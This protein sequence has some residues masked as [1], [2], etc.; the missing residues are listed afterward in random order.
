MKLTK[1]RCALCL[2]VFFLSLGPPDLG[3]QSAGSP[4]RAASA[5]ADVPDI[6]TRIKNSG[7]AVPP[8]ALPAVPGPV[9]SALPPAPDVPVASPA[10]VPPAAIGPEPAPVDASTP[11][12]AA[13]I[14][15]RVDNP[16]SGLVRLGAGSPET[17]FGDLSVRREDGTLPALALDFS[18]ASAD[19]YGYE[20]PG[21][22]YFDRAAQAR[23]GASSG[24]TSGS[25]PN[26]P[27]A[28]AT[29]DGAPGDASAGAR[30]PAWFAD[31]SLFDGSDG[32]QGKNP[33]YYAL[34]RRDVGWSL[35]LR[36]IA[37]GSSAFSLSAVADGS[38]DS[39]FAE[40]PSANSSSDD[41]AADLDAADGAT[42]IDDF[43]GYRLS[44]SLVLAFTKGAFLA[45]LSG[46]YGYET[47]LERG[48]LHDGSGDLALRYGIGN[49]NLLASAG[50]AGDGGTGAT[51]DGI[52]FPF[53]V[54]FVWNPASVDVG[55][56]VGDAPPVIAG[57]SS[58]P[59]ELRLSFGITRERQSARTLAKAEPFA[60]TAGLSVFSADWDG[61][62]GFAL[63]TE[64]NNGSFLSA[65]ADAV[66]RKSLA[67]HGILALTDDLSDASLVSV[68]RVERDSFVTG[69]EAYY[70]ASAFSLSAR[71]EGEWLDRL[72]R[73]SLHTA[74]VGANVYDRGA[75]RVW[76]AGVQ[77]AFAL[78]RADY[79]VLSARGTVR[80][81]RNF[82]VTLSALDMLPLAAGEERTRN[83]LYTVRSGELTLS[84]T[85]NF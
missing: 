76:E 59:R 6:E 38:V 12:S 18:Y 48:E 43:A 33:R 23:F 50:V 10:A 13:E 27:T 30:S 28:A 11:V 78:D 83:G 61:S 56:P 62:L 1:L 7:N 60:D 68:R 15:A 19:G 79:P 67:G 49:L 9:P 5:D 55:S 39:T 64:T 3:A 21:T 51:G 24:V 17:L 77:S 36:S 74:T 58:V 4:K 34:T 57:S 81:F 75:D 54:G 32:F 14:E 40:G 73:R 22:G 70:S 16:V 25:P 46:R 2:S 41:S 63:G 65:R 45:T 42:K 69:V 71:Y 8:A 47:A 26:A 66:Y 72:Y 20:K 29:A 31:L 52:V 35:G 85:L 84:A 53:S 44:P 80:P 37:L 82:S